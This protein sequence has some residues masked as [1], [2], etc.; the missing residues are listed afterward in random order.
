MPEVIGAFGF[1]LF[2]GLVACGIG[3]VVFP[4]SLPGLSSAS[5]LAIR[6]MLGFGVI[7]TVAMLV[8]WGVGWQWLPFL[9]VLLIVVAVLGW[10]R[11]G[12]PSVREVPPGVFAVCVLLLFLRLPAGLA[13][14]DSNDWD[15]LSHQ[16]AMAR[17][18]LNSG[19]IEYIPFMPHSN[20]PGLVNIL[21]IFGLWAGDQ[22]AAK[23]LTVL[24]LGLGALTVA[25]I[26]GARYGKMA[27]AWAALAVLASPVLL[28][29]AGTG[30]VDIPHGLWAALAVLAFAWVYA[31]DEQQSARPWL[32]LGG[33]FMG[34][35][36]GS[37]YTALPIA[38]ILLVCLFFLVLRRGLLLKP[39]LLAITLATLVALPWY[40]RNVV[41]TGNPFYPFLY[42]V[43]DGRNWS[44]ENAAAFR[45]EQSQFGIGVEPGGR[46]DPSALGGSIT[47]LALQPDRQINRASP[48]GATGAVFLLAPLL[49]AFSG[50]ARRF[51]LVLLLVLLLSLVAWFFMTQQSRYL[52][53]LIFVSSVLAGGV[54]TLR[55]RALAIAAIALQVAWCFTLFAYFN[56]D[57]LAA[58]ISVSM[59]DMTR[60]EY[61]SAR[62]DFWPGVQAINSLEEGA[63]VAL[64]DEVRGFYL[65][66]DYFWANPQHST[67]IPY[68][69]LSGG[70][71]LVKHL[72]RLGVT[73]VYIHLSPVV[74]GVERAN[75]LAAAFTDTSA[76][77]EGEE[78]FRQLLIEAVRHGEL[79]LLS[80]QITSSGRLV[81]LLY[82]VP[83]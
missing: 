11:T 53:G 40:V 36:L 27:A 80:S 19:G 75:R 24:F 10:R 51:E 57:E 4:H 64:Y 22:Y 45:A 13:P 44:D 39:A 46:V 6:A 76:P 52:S 30:Y 42:S 33:L 2:A 41:N 25:G 14:S 47:G 32:L 72:R 62:F 28:W 68:E 48:F 73:H 60:E 3:G 65:K 54:M 67:M 59:G 79:R 12:L 23:M 77:I 34:F 18:W 81:S 1:A 78:R 49:W 17:I 35:A 61:L 8:G 37:K 5:T 7:G 31:D 15:T 29:E 70:E 82:I 56:R 58:Q 38:I 71:E 20:V 26:A 83:R 63:K 69:T 50:R 55:Y 9:T 43:F 16:L 74:L 66:R 21:Y